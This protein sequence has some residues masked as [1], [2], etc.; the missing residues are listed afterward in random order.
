M[1]PLG[2]TTTTLTGS[3]LSDETM[4]SV[5][6]NSNNNIDIDTGSST[7]TSTRAPTKTTLHGHGSVPRLLRAIELVVLV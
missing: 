1:E 5:L 4:L 6:N 2:I 7:V 3:M